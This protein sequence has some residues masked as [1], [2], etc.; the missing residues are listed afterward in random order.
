M[1]TKKTLWIARDR[2]GEL[3]LFFNKPKEGI[4]G[5]FYDRTV[6]PIDSVGL[7]ENDFADITYENSPVE[8]VVKLK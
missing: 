3:G 4:G 8:V 1:T 2:N 5:T 6:L 7:D